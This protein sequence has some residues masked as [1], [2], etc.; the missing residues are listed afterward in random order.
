[1]SVKSTKKTEK[2]KAGKTTKEATEKTS[3]VTSGSVL[4]PTFHYPVTAESATQ[5]LAD[6][7]FP[8]EYN[9]RGVGE[10][11]FY[12]GS[13][14]VGMLASPRNGRQYANVPTAYGVCPYR[15]VGLPLEVVLNFQ[16]AVAADKIT[17]ILQLALAAYG[18]ETH[19]EV[20]TPTPRAK[21]VSQS[22]DADA[23]QVTSAV[24]DLTRLVG[25]LA[26]KV[27]ALS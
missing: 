10:I 1:M 9:T 5:A 12:R 11:T 3:A 24:S 14:P 7:G 6:A 23:Q 19:D 15:G 17:H 26:V 25:A 8:A 27:D 21:T 13:V 4:L 20:T 22:G 18:K 2:R 16:H